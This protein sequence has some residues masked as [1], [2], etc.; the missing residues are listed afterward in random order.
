MLGDS[1]LVAPVFAPDGEVEYYLP[2][3]RWTDFL[4]GQVAEG[5]RWVREKHGYLSLPLMARPNSVIPVGSNDQKPDYDYA[6][7]VTFHV[8]ELLDGARLSAPMPTT[9]GD[10]TMTLDV[11]RTG[12]Q[13]RVRAQ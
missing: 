6:D 12:Q 11:S 7:G 8:F 4:S 9:R 3:G 2:R 1:L 13:I 5:G 10:V